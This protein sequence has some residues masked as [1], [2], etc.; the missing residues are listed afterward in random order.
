[1][2][3]VIILQQLGKKKMKKSDYTVSGSSSVVGMREVSR[4][5]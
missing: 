1:M 5:E 2:K 4:R 3:T